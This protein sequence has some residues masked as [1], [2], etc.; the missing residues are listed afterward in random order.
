M[1]NHNSHTPAVPTSQD[2]IR[3]PPS[4]PGA[5]PSSRPVSE[6]GPR[7]PS[8]HNPENLVLPKELP[9]M[10][11]LRPVSMEMSKNNPNYENIY[12][13]KSDGTNVDDANETNNNV[14]NDS[15]INSEAVNQPVQ[16]GHIPG[17]TDVQSVSSLPNGHMQ[18]PPPPPQ[19]KITTAKT[20]YRPSHRRQMSLGQEHTIVE[21]P[22]ENIDLRVKLDPLMQ[23][24]PGATGPSL[25]VKNNFNLDYSYQCTYVQLAEHRRN[26]TMED[27]E[28]RTGKKLSDLSADLSEH[29]EKPSFQRD[30][31]S[32]VSSR[33][34]GSGVSKKKKAPAP[35]GQ[36][37][38]L[39]PGSSHT[40]PLPGKSAP[41]TPRKEAY[42]LDNEPPIDYDMESPRRPPPPAQQFQL[43]RYTAAQLPRAGSSA[44][45]APPVPP[46]P[47]TGMGTRK[48]VTSVSRS[49]S[50]KE[51]PHLIFKK[52]PDIKPVPKSADANLGGQVPWLLEIKNLSEAKAARRQ[53]SQESELEAPG[54]Q[55]DGD[56]QATDGNREVEKKEPNAT[57][58]F[59]SSNENIAVEKKTEKETINKTLERSNSLRELVKPPSPKLQ[60]HSSTTTFDRLSQPSVQR[61]ISK[62]ST[63]SNGDPVRRLSS[64]LQHDIKAT[65]S[66]KCL[67][68]VKQTTPVPPKPKD[69][70][71]VFREQLQKACAARDER[72]SVEGTID[73]KLKKSSNDASFEL[74]E[75]VGEENV[76]PRK[77]TAKTEPP[78]VLPKPPRYHKN[79]TLNRNSNMYS[80]TQRAASFTDPSPNR[81]GSSRQ[82]VSMSLDWTPE[83]DLESDDNLSDR[84]TVTGRKGSSD[85][86]KSSIV[87]NNMSEMKAKKK[88]KKEKRANGYVQN[89]DSKA[90]KFGS[91]KKFKKSMHRSVKNAFGSISKASGKILRKQ[92]AEDLETVDDAPRNWSLTSAAANGKA[93]NRVGKY[94]RPAAY[95]YDE[96]GTD[97]DSEQ[98]NPEQEFSEI[99]VQQNGHVESDESSEHENRSPELRRSGRTYKAGKSQRMD[100]SDEEEE[101]I[102]SPRYE[103]AMGKDKRSKYVYEPTFR[104]REQEA[105]YAR[106]LEEIRARERKVEEDKRKQLEIELEMHKI[107]E[108]ETRERLKRL[109]EAQMHQQVTAQLL[110]QQ[111]QQ[112]QQQT[113][114]HQQHQSLGML[115]APALPAVGT[116]PSYGSL[117]DPNQNPNFTNIFGQQ[118]PQNGFQS[119]FGLYSQ[120]NPYMNGSVPSNMSYDLNDYMRM[121]GQNPPTSQQMAFF[122]NNMTLTGQPFDRKSNPLLMDMPKQQYPTSTL[123]YQGLDTNSLKKQNFQTWVSSP[124][125]ST[126]HQTSTGVDVPINDFV[127]SYNGA[128]G[129]G[130]GIS[131]KMDTEVEP[132]LKSNNPLYNSDDSDSGLTPEK[133]VARVQVKDYRQ[134]PVRTESGKF[135]RKYASDNLQSNKTSYSQNQDNFSQSSQNISQPGDIQRQ[136]SVSP[137]NSVS[138]VDS[139]ITSPSQTLSTSSSPAQSIGIPASPMLTPRSENITPSFRTVVDLTSGTPNSTTQILLSNGEAVKL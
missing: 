34:S 70:H 35:P 36:A 104:K 96:E 29:V 4:R 105:E 27:L 86:F 24:F 95:D 54:S 82:Q 113:Q 39:A 57:L 126:A 102:R 11:K 129:D 93:G 103:K 61:Q 52:T 48:P 71:T 26:K 16:N 64:L 74:G 88:G 90:N 40:L 68:L 15:E 19:P 50:F 7:G 137:S 13:T 128:N 75:V 85:G 72:A 98:Y 53:Q 38:P 41:S 63:T 119:N 131:A 94:Q 78:D 89:E 125:I 5:P 87:P 42:S 66:A 30:A 20:P 130:R 6:L 1:G 118:I 106:E 139:A 112:Q 109:E 114:L 25:P 47:P 49:A 9:S 134:I 69:P 120:S 37:P 99:M 84:E 43:P 33:S 115:S 59:Q 116:F 46:P 92:K 79:V 76:T 73:E 55:N 132:K 67:K 111:Q 100:M 31:P 28:K 12:S 22:E 2:V 80:K 32:R 108:A 133:T 56:E 97:S 62:P 60:R 136:Q 51:T 135:M 14:K 10:L 138:T 127:A 45:R 123:T 107:R 8:Y 122:L 124:N 110:Q 23:S 21:E 44:S 121:L 81:P 17:Q 65:A 77:D 83:V 101:E 117:P 3:R 18:L 58:V 91:V